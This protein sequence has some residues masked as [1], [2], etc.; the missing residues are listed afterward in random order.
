M[1]VALVIPEQEREIWIWDLTRAAL[2]ILSCQYLKIQEISD[3]RKIPSLRRTLTDKKIRRLILSRRVI[4]FL[5][6]RS[7][8]RTGQTEEFCQT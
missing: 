1:R 5:F 2:T 6:A 4:G 8:S 7:R 3:F